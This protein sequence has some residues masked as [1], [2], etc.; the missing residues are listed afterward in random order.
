MPHLT[1]ADR[2]KLTKRE[3]SEWRKRIVIAEYNNWPDKHE[4][5]DYLGM[6]YRGCVVLAHK[7]GASKPTPQRNCRTAHPTGILYDTKPT[8][9]EPTDIPPGPHKLPVLEARAWNG[10]ELFP[11]GDMEPNLE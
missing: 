8:E 10:E 1:P 11:D 4:L 5:A 2:D 9:A 6:S 3:L 7:H